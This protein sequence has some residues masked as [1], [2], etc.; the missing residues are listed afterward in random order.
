MPLGR[1]TPP[2]G[3]ASD[4]GGLAGKKTNPIRP[5]LFA[6]KY[7]SESPNDFPDLPVVKTDDQDA[8]GVASRLARPFLKQRCEVPN[9]ERHENAVGGR[10]HRQNIWVGEPLK[11]DVLVKGKNVVS[12]LAKCFPDAFSGDVRVEEYAGGYELTSKVG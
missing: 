10:S 4:G 9:V 2:S 12:G 7:G 3:D 11:S 8:T 6:L 1:R 5:D